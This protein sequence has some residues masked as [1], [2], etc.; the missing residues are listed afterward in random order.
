M[1]LL[2]K[3]KWL[4]V[5]S[6]MLVISCKTKYN[7]GIPKEPQDNIGA[8]FHD[9]L[10]LETS[11]VWNDSVNTTFNRLNTPWLMAGSYQDRYFGKTKATSYVAIYPFPASNFATQPT[12]DSVV[13]SV[14]PYT[15]QDTAFAT[16]VNQPF[17][18]YEIEDNFTWP[19]ANKYFIFSQAISRKSL[20]L[21]GGNF[22]IAHK[23]YKAVKSY[24]TKL[25][26]EYG[27]KLLAQMQLSI[28][29]FLNVNP[30]IV[31][32]SGADNGSKMFTFRTNGDTLNNIT[33][34]YKDINGRKGTQRF[35]FGTDSSTFYRMEHD[36][37]G[38]NFSNLNEANREISTSQTGNL[39]YVQTGVG[40]YTKIKFPYLNQI[41]NGRN[42]LINKAEIVVTCPDATEIP[43]ATRPIMSV[44]ETN[45]ENY[46]SLSKALPLEFVTLSNGNREIRYYTIY[47]NLTKGYTFDITNYVQ[48][49]IYNPDVNSGLILGGFKPTN[50]YLVDRAV[51]YDN[52]I[53]G[54]VTNANRMKL[55]LYYTVIDK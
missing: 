17:K 40:L 52:K 22:T 12:L 15:S 7:I 18:V 5:V 24:R 10:T 39:C 13:M 8:F 27:N 3:L 9:T 16:S 54:G 21:T 43:Y 23:S 34:Y 28:P 25:D 19:Y 51:F 49:L 42:I 4:T 30:G 32:E 26:M 50:T 33:L 6:A 55:N 46:I 48:K 35:L 1:N 29:D 31:L 14:W 53:S 11:V 41:A 20:D 37:S 47:N 2:G 38:T 44:Y 36:W 45:K